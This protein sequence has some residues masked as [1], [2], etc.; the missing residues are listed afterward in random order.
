M[1]YQWRET[2]AAKQY[3]TKNSKNDTEIK[4]KSKQKT[5]T[6]NQK[7]KKPNQHFKKSNQK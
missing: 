1:A 4:Q 7:T 2:V 5:K 6:S 3:K